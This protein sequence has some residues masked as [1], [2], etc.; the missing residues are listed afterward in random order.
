MYDYPYRLERFVTHTGEV[1][2][3]IMRTGEGGI[4]QGENFTEMR[5]LVEAV[6]EVEHREG[7]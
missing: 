7:R 5:K 2:Y 6:N 3:V 4:C 1:T